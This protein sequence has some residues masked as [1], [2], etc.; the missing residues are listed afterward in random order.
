MMNEKL[1]EHV[2]G[3][4]WPYKIKDDGTAEI[5]GK[6]LALARRRAGDSRETRRTYCDEHR[7]RGVRAL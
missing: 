2:G 4:D 7:G 3:Y 6:P 5:I 1:I